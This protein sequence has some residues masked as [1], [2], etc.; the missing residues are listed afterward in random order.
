M[1]T[2]S[3]DLRSL[4]DETTTL[5][6]LRSHSCLREVSGL[7][8][9]FTGG[10]EKLRDILQSASKYLPFRAWISEPLTVTIHEGPHTVYPH[11]LGFQ[12]QTNIEL[13]YPAYRNVSTLI[14]T[15]FHEYAHWLHKQEEILTEAQWESFLGTVQDSDCSDRSSIFETF[16]NDF[17]WFCTNPSY[18]CIT[19]P[20]SFVFFLTF[21]GYRGNHAFQKSGKFNQCFSIGVNSR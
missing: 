6:R 13:Y 21:M 16:A 1:Q 11:W 15:F 2:Q 7:S 9:S 10:T 18:M 12:D 4:S 17:A 19:K 5:F 20:E 3:A 14:F 8:F